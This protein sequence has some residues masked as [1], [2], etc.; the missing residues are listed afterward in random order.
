MPER[1]L[2]GH[3]DAVVLQLAIDER[4]VASF[5]D[6]E[7][8][9]AQQVRMIVDERDRTGGAELLVGIRDE[10]N[11]ARE[12]DAAALERDHRH[13][14]DDAF[15]LHV[16]RA[17]SVHEPILDRAAVRVDGPVAGVRWYDVDVM[18][19]RDGLLRPGPLEPRVQV[20]ATG[21]E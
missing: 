15:S 1:T 8:D 4:I 21:A 10:D 14:M 6:E 3:T 5:R 19:E 13:E 11:V 2:L 17:T 7:L 12:R 9:V 16:E 18:H 20:W